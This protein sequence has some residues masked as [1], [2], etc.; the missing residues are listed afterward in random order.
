MILSP[1]RRKWQ[2]TPVFSSPWRIPWIE[3]GLQSIGSQRVGH[4]WTD[5]VCT[6]AWCFT[7]D[8]LILTR[9][10]RQRE[11]IEEF[12][13]HSGWTKNF[14]N[15]W[16]V[17]TAKGS[18]KVHVVKAMVFLWSCM[19]VRVGLWRRLSAEELMLLNCGVGE[20]S[21]ESLGLQG[22]PTSPFWRRSAL[23]FPWKEWC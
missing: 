5:L 20:D 10:W 6:H 1:W 21:W 14:L 2:P 9:V 7:F 3:K 8:L 19:D 4:D 12:V 11:E 17:D 22:D 13:M 18:T 16:M 23:G 15:R